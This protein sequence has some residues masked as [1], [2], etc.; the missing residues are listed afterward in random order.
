MTLEELKKQVREL[1]ERE[2]QVCYANPFFDDLFR[3]TE[4]GM[5]G[6]HLDEAT[7]KEVLDFV[8]ANS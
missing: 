8:R 2:Y 7:A 3:L 4:R 6:N 5:R 1:S